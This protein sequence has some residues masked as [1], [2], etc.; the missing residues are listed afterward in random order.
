MGVNKTFRGVDR[1]SV[2]KVQELESSF[3]VSNRLFGKVQGNGY[4]IVV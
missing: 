2:G 3:A 1:C 4:Q